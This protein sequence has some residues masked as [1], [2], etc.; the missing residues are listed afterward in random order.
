M[1][2]LGP[3]DYVLTAVGL[4]GNTELKDVLED[5]VP[6]VKYAGGALQRGNALDAIREGYK[7]GLEV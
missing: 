1:K 5:V 2:E 3:F 7:A 4:H 6:V